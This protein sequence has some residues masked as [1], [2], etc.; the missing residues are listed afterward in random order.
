MIRIQ[1]GGKDRLPRPWCAAINPTDEPE[2]RSSSGRGLKARPRDVDVVSTANHRISSDG[3]P[4]FISS[5]V[6]LNETA[7]LQVAPPSVDLFTCIV[8]RFCASLPKPPSWTLPRRSLSTT[9]S[10][11]VT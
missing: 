8:N 5:I 4:L 3:E 6:L 1:H 11:T 10:R 7:S 2:L 9:R